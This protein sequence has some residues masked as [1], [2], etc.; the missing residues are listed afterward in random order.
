MAGRREQKA[1][2]YEIAV[3]TVTWIQQDALSRTL[4]L[5]GHQTLGWQTEVPW[6]GKDAKGR[7]WRSI[8]RRRVR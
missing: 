6:L 7:H 4:E 5:D 8:Q 2:L 1:D 3:D